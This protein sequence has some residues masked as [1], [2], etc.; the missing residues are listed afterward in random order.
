MRRSNI[1]LGLAAIGAVL[2]LVGVRRDDATL[3]WV[4]IGW[5]AAAFLSRFLDRGASSE[6]GEELAG[7]RARASTPDASSAD[8]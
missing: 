1:K 5:F 3:R 2:F 7:S 4:G 6:R 8:G